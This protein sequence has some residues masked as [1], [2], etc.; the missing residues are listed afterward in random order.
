MK[1]QSRILAALFLFNLM[2]GLAVPN[3]VL[4]G[5]NTKNNA[6]IDYPVQTPAT[7]FGSIIDEKFSLTTI[8]AYSS[9]PEQTDSSPFITASGYPVEDGIIASNFLEFNTKV[10][11]PDLYGEKIFIVKDRMAKKNSDKIDIWFPSTEEALKFGVKKARIEI[12]ES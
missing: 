9:T 4:K 8:T 3:L 10:R 7:G 5:I 1:N 2:P 11:I 6:I 12:V